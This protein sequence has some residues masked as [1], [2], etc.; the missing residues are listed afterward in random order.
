MRRGL[1]SAPGTRRRAVFPRRRRREP[2]MRAAVDAQGRRVAAERRGAAEGKHG[3]RQ[4]TVPAVLAAVG[5]GAQRVADDAVGPLRLG[6]GVPVVRRADDQARAHALDQGAEHVAGELGVVQSWPTTSA[7][8]K[9]APD[10]RG[11]SRTIAAAAAPCPPPPPSGAWGRH[12]PCR[13][14]G[15][16]RSGS[17]F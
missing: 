10:R 3:E 14:A 12:A 6:V 13:T 16:R 1:L 8:G 4:A 2:G 11:M 7:F 17:L 5:A 9:P 15:R